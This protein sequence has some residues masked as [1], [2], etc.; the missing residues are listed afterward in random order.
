MSKE[1]IIP[2]EK[3][4]YYI[5]SITNYSCGLT[6]NLVH[7]AASLL[8]FWINYGYLALWDMVDRLTH[9]PKLGLDVLFARK[10]LRSWC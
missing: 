5:I 3:H 7:W 1:I 2:S 9:T 10:R 6:V 8:L 4:T